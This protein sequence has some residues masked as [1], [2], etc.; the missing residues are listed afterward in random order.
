M[1]L[2]VAYNLFDGEELLEF[3]AKSIR[4]CVDHIL[5]VYQDVSNYGNKTSTDVLG[6]LN[7]LKEKGLIDEIVQYQPN[8]GLKGHGNEIA[9]RNLGLERCGQA[10]CTHFMT[11]DIDEFYKEEEL[12]FVKE[13]V[14]GDKYD[15]S[16]CQM[17]TYYKTAEWA[18]TPPESY[19]VPLIYKID[20]RRFNLNVRWPISADPT[21]RLEPKKLMIFMRDKIEMHHMSYVRKDIR[22][23]LNNS[24]ANVNWKNRIEELAAYHDNWTPLKMARFAGSEER[25]YDIKQVPNYFNINI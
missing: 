24:S 22:A 5:V 9:K 8:I 25:L 4:N 1:K 10:G 14:E 19:Y 3:S 18:I 2:G 17:Q 6:L 7:T 15:S 23:K 21:R 12:K 11:M 13:F 16:A 20:E